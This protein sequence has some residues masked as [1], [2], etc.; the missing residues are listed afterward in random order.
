MSYVDAKYDAKHGVVLIAERI[1]GERKQLR[2]PAPLFFFYADSSGEYISTTGVKCSKFQTS[3]NNVFKEEI[4]SMKHLGREVF[5]SD[6]KPVFKALEEQYSK[7][8]ELPELNIAL[9]D[10]ETLWDPDN[11][12]SSPDEAFMPINAVSVKQSWTKKMHTLVLKPQLMPMN[13]AQQIVAKFENTVLCDS[14]SQLLDKLLILLEDADIISGWNSEG[15]DIPYIVNRIIKVRGKKDSTRLCLWKQYPKARKYLRYGKESSTYDLVG[16]I[17]LDYLQLYRKYTYHELPT[18]RLD[19]VGGIE[20]DENKVP[21]EGTLDEL[22]NKDFEKFVSYSRQDVEILYKLDQKLKYINLVNFVAHEN[23]VTIPYV[24]GSVVLSDNAILLETHRR[25]MVAPDGHDNTDNSEELSEYLSDE[26]SDEEEINSKIAGAFVK[27][28][29][30]GMY[31]WIGSVDINSLYPSTFRALNMSP[32]TLVGHIEQTL[33]EQMMMEKQQKSRKKLNNAEIWSGVFE[34]PE[35]IEV[36]NKTKTRLTLR[37]NDDGRTEELTAEQIWNKLEKNNWLISA[38]GVIFRTDKQ[39]VVP[40]LLSS[41][42]KE[43]KEYQKKLKQWKELST[44]V[45][46]SEP[47]LKELQKLFDSGKKEV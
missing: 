19:Y 1:N 28:P 40:S 17:H 22:Y 25:G 4:A 46:L 34:I 6:V 2:I 36:Q 11:G 30:P 8:K 38:N 5:E 43:R 23:L 16:R 21:Y 35:V 41:W 12:F 32:E 29:V 44:G 14:E 27:D 13:E 42:Y 37:Y 47:V 3:D 31:E 24:M 45:E 9:I 7:N 18:Y 20:V 26:D 10:I 15:F 39:G 33:T